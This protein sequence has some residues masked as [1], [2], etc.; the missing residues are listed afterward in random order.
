MLI[1]AWNLGIYLSMV[2]MANGTNVDMWLI[3]VVGRICSPGID[4]WS[5]S[6]ATERGLDWV[7]MGPAKRPK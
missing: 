1:K 6:L 4:K 7:D 2:N 3:S 5:N